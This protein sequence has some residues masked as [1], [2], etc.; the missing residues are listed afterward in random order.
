MG[1]SKI[2]I[3][4]GF[5]KD[6]INV[7]DVTM[8]DNNKWQ[9]SRVMYSLY[10]ASKEKKQPYFALYGD[11]IFKRYLLRMML[12]SVAENPDADLVLVCVNDDY[13]GN[14]FTLILNKSL[15][16]ALYDDSCIE[17]IRLSTKE[18]DGNVG[19]SVFF[20][21]LMLIKNYMKVGQILDSDD[22]ESITCED[23]LQRALENKLKIAAIV[24]SKDSIVD[25]NTVNDIIEA[26]EVYA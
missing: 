25:I 22:I 7:P 10:L 6:E 2:S 23:F 11:V 24:S 19:N 14:N 26:G 21:G 16:S 3:V 18:A 5:M 17:V 20:S 9:S 15:D 12:D 8:I 13:I 1:I 4:R